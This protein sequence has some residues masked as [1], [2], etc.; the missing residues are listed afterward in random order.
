MDV[1]G[2]YGSD[3]IMKAEKMAGKVDAERLGY[4]NNVN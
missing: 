4:I 3:G 2:L 1:L